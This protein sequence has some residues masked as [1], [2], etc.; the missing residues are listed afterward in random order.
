MDQPM[1]SNFTGAPDEFAG[2]PLGFLPAASASE[3]LFRS[4]HVP[5]ETVSGRQGKGPFVVIVRSR[6]ELVRWLCDPPD[7]LQW[8]QVEGLLG[9]REAW[10]LAAQNVSDVPLDVILAAPA[11]EFSDLYCLV[12][13]SAARDV[14]VSMPAVPGFLKAVRL[15]ASLGLPIRLFASQPS[16][17]TIAE[18][19]AA[20]D[21]YLHDPVVEAPVEFFHAVLAWMLGAPTASLWRIVEEDPAVFRH[22]DA[23]GRFRGPRAVQT[24]RQETSAPDFV[25]AHLARLVAGGAECAT[26]RWQ[27]VCQGYFKWPY[28]GYSCQ[29]V[30]Q[31]FST[32]R[33]AKP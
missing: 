18:I 28:P 23:G 32:I 3:V 30:K 11:A 19:A 5:A 29:G 12:E 26:C 31:L 7:G 9:D 13:V 15:A 21:F 33:A 14:R 20:L 10:A 2:Q 6:D 22:Y 1:I 24:S 8:L 17:E 25:Q 16:A 27:P 4:S